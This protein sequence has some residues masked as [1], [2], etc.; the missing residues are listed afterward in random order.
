MEGGREATGELE[1]ILRAYALRSR[2][3]RLK[4][5]EMSQSSL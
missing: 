1:K 4:I 3:R 5:D 2:A